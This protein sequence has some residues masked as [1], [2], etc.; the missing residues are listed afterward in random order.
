MLELLLQ[1]KKFVPGFMTEM[2]Y[3]DHCGRIVGQN[4]KNGS[5]GQRLESFAGFENGQGAQKPDRVQ[6]GV[7]F[8]HALEIGVVFQSVHKDVTNRARDLLA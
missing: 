6:C 5:F 1:P 2:R 4:G 7:V 8:A 3:V